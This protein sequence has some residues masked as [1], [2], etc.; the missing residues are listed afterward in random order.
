VIIDVHDGARLTYFGRSEE[1]FLGALL[2]T[3][4]VITGRVVSPQAGALIRPR[5]SLDN[6]LVT[7]GR[8]PS[9]PL[10]SVIADAVE[11]VEPL[12]LSS[13]DDSC[14]VGSGGGWLGW[15]FGKGGGGVFVSM[16]ARG[17]SLLVEVGGVVFGWRTA[18]A[19]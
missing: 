10:V 7:L 2:G 12:R 6:V 11:S 9:T 17:S 19:G 15:R 5:S 8:P 1:Y 13:C 18:P 3:L 16:V 4:G 14:L